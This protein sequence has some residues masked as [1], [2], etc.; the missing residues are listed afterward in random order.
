MKL[1]TV[2]KNPVFS[3]SVPVI[4]ESDPVNAEVTNTPTKKLIE[5]DLALKAMLESKVEPN[6]GMGFSHNDFTDEYKE[7]VE[8]LNGLKFGQDAGGNWGYVAPGTTEVVPFG[9]GGGVES[10]GRFER[11]VI[12]YNSNANFEG[13]GI[14][15]AF[16]DGFEYKYGQVFIEIVYSLYSRYG[17]EGNYTTGMVFVDRTQGSLKIPLDGTLISSGRMLYL[18]RMATIQNAQNNGVV[19]AGNKII[20]SGCSSYNLADGTYKDGTES[21][22][23]IV[24]MYCFL[25]V[26]NK[27]TRNGVEI[28]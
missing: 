7:A 26:N 11:I 21:D 28:Q 20:V 15:A 13:G 18:K 2:S 27:T 5:N 10:D 14:L 25:S 3:A 1:Y 22:I 4:E 23:Y 9:N 17:S 16:P 24:P 8:G 6:E 12:G 19:S